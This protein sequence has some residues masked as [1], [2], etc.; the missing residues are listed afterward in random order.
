MRAVVHETPGLIDVKSFTTMGLN[1]KPNSTNPI[2]YF[3]TGL[4]YAIAVL[5]RHGQEVTVWIGDNPHV[6]YG[7]KISFREKEF[8]Q[9]Y[10]RRKRGIK[11]IWHSQELPFTTEFGK[12]WKV[13]MAFRE[14]HSNTLDEKGLT[15]SVL[16]SDRRYRKRHDDADL[17]GNDVG[18][19]SIEGREG[20]TRI[21]VSGEDYAKAF[22]NMDDIFLRDA[23]VDPSQIQ[24]IDRKSKYVYYRGL[25]VM[26]LEQEAKYTW[27]F[28][29]HMQLT[30]DR[31]LDGQHMVPYYIIKK[32]RESK[33]KDYIK[34]MMVAP[35]NTWEGGLPWDTWDFVTTE[36]FIEV[37]RSYGRAKAK[38]VVHSYDMR[39]FDSR[40]GPVDWRNSV[41]SALES[42]D[43]ER[44]GKACKTFSQY[45]INLIK[46]SQ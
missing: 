18:D 39:N 5:C 45:I 28:Y 40:N 46:A 23:K 21:V 25:R 44:I 41:L 26:D 6:F 20:Y 13:W 35:E 7:K 2:G 10:M 27:N 1:V 9:L 43:E 19:W 16:D 32:T 29:H 30:E 12:N 42:E 3:G 22:D 33:D 14:L 38:G 37:A 34:K 36:E 24:V 15:Y 8:T 4:K 11:S 31:T 17:E